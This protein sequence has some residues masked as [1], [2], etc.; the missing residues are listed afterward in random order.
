MKGIKWM[1]FGIAWML[2]G[3]SCLL[4]SALFGGGGLELLGA[5]CPVL[6][7]IICLLAVTMKEERKRDRRDIPAGLLLFSGI[8]RSGPQSRCPKCP[9]SKK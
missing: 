5:L 2:L 4:A 9:W 1:L 3:I 8:I 7:V 6:G